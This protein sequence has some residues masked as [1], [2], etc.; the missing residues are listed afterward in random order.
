MLLFFN[1]K[2][3]VLSLENGSLD[4]FGDFAVALVETGVTKR[5]DSMITPRSYRMG[6][7]CEVG[8]R[9]R[10][11]GQVQKLVLCRNPAFEK[12]KKG[13]RYKLEPK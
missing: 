13:G 8:P 2:Y 5:A 12:A 7:S 6:V 11:Q 9:G 10:R 1:L 4:D 3:I